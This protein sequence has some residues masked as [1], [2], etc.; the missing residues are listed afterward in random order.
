MGFYI[1]RKLTPR[2]HYIISKRGAGRRRRCHHH[3]RP[4]ILPRPPLRSL[5]S[6]CHATLPHSSP[7]YRLP[8]RSTNMRTKHICKMNCARVHFH[9][10]GSH[11]HS[12]VSTCSKNEKVGR[13]CRETY[14]HN[15][16][17]AQC[18][19]NNANDDRDNEE[20]HTS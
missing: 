2:G 17:T 15:I 3:L 14:T 4:A 9:L 1:F 18:D 8:A 7:S 13:S 12:F 5:R 19:G 20:R 16:R 10:T 11:E 6:L